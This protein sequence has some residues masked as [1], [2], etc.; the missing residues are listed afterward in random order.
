LE[1]LPPNLGNENIS[2]NL[3]PEMK[4]DG[5]YKEIYDT[6]ASLCIIMNSDGII[7]DCNRALVK[8]L[9]YSGKNAIISRS[10]L[11]F[12]YQNDTNSDGSTVAN[13]LDVWKRTGK[14]HNREFRM[15]RSDGSIFP[16]LM[17]ANSLYDELGRIIGCNASIVNITELDNIRRKAD[18]SMNELKAKE[19]DLLEINE[20]LI[21]VEK[22][23]E[24]FISMVS[25][26][27]KNPLT[28]ILAF[29][30]FLFKKMKDSA[31]SSGQQGQ[32]TK[33]EIDAIQTIRQN[34]QDMKQL[35]DDVLSVYKLDMRIKF[36]FSETNPVKIVEQVLL[37]LESILNEKKILIERCILLSEPENTIISCD[38]LRIRQVL[39]N[40]IRN[41]VDFVPDSEVNS[42]G[43][44]ITVTIN[45]L[46]EEELELKKDQNKQQQLQNNSV[47][48]SK[49]Q[50]SFL[51]FSIADNG[52]GVPIEK[53][54]GLFKKFYQIDTKG[55]RRYGG[56]G[57]GLTICKEIVEMH[58]G[59]IWYDSTYGKGACFRFMLPLKAYQRLSQKNEDS[60]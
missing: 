1:S 45:Y 47:T 52:P 49:L 20:K 60:C 32:L 14:L 41:S 12:V 53:V 58:G 26:E 5:W 35:I 57:L 31:A 24:E 7:L 11:E 46:E 51:L 56:T 17:N 16:V 44:K 42:G 10:F 22:A 37:D 8:A 59:K 36:S 13:S 39:V 34:A 27:L 50:P 3:L 18:L 23:K 28:P 4:Q 19:R 15:K 2:L 43:G 30:E 33:K 55:I 6:S 40:L 25:H 48:T 54:S 38:P 29:S 21:R 9:G